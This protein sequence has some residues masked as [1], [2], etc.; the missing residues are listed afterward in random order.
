ML[1]F[2]ERSPI[3]RAKNPVSRSRDDS[4]QEQAHG[5]R[6]QVHHSLGIMTDGQRP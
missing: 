1:V 2:I 5:E 4:D 6:A 3:E